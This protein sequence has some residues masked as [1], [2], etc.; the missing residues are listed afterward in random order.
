MNRAISISELLNTKFNVL[1]FDGEFEALIGKPELKGAWLVWGGS[2]N[3]KTT[4]VLQLV[5]Y[6]CR[7]GRVAYD[8]MEEGRSQSMKTNFMRNNMAEVGR[9][10]I[11]LDNE[12]I[13]DL[14]ERLRKHKSPSIIVIDSLQYS[15]MNYR[16]F[17]AL[18]DEFPNK[19]FII[20]SHA[21]G[22]EP[23]GRVGKQI[24][25][26][27]FV[28]IRVEGFMASAMSRYLETASKDYCIWKEGADRYWQNMNE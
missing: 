10:L 2:S 6:M 13:E 17:I 14:K 3:G 11:L 7:F 20:I 18:R 5:K 24:K 15:G 23:S 16:S 19:L 8:S 25:Y 4:F 28:K 27:A 26:D 1:D 22:K 12:S 21:D 9:K